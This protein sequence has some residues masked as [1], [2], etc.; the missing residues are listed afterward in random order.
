M[1]FGAVDDYYATGHGKNFRASCSY[2]TD[3]S[4]DE[5]GLKSRYLELTSQ[6]RYP[7]ILRGYHPFYA[8]QG[9]KA[10]RKQG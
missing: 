7:L 8:N 4:L 6:G 5:A 1:G 3:Q 9:I 10:L 2:L